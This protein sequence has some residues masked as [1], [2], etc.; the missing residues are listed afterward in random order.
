MSKFAWAVY[1]GFT[2]VLVG[3]AVIVFLTEKPRDF[4]VIIDRSGSIIERSETHIGTEV[5]SVVSSSDSVPVPAAIL[6]ERN[7]GGGDRSFYFE[8]KSDDRRLPRRIRHG[9]AK[10]L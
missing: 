3:G 1:V 4:E 6:R 2:L 8:E 10:E 9:D 7:F 5:S